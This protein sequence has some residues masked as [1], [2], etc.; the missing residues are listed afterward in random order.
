M[1]L[2][3]NGRPHKINSLIPNLTPP[4]YVNITPKYNMI[5]DHTTY[6]WVAIQ[7]VIRKPITC[8]TS[9]RHP[10]NHFL[11]RMI[12][13][14]KKFGIRKSKIFSAIELGMLTKNPKFL[15]RKKYSVANP[16]IKQF[17]F[18]EWQNGSVNDNHFQTFF[19]HIT[20]QFIF[21]QLEKM[22]ES[23]ILMRRK[24]KMSLRDIIFIQLRVSKI[25]G[26]IKTIKKQQLERDLTYQV[27]HISP[28]DCHLYDHVNRSI[29]KEITEGGE[30]LQQE[31]K[32]FRKITFQ[33][34]EYCN[35]TLTRIRDKALAL[36]W[37]PSPTLNR[38]LRL[39]I[40]VS[41]KSVKFRTKYAG[42]MPFAEMLSRKPLVIPTNKWGGQFLVSP[43]DCATMRLEERALQ[44]YFYFNQN[45]DY[46]KQVQRRC[47]A[48]DINVAGMDCRR[49]CDN[50]KEK[51][52]L[53]FSLV[54]E[55][56]AYIW[57]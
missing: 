54:N 46:C 36:R 2:F 47:P 25:Q 44:N 18:P 41:K 45:W 21:V 52:D 15:R 17:G 56:G 50:S 48:S 30:D 35:L 38:F 27:C 43:L 3:N 8:V 34:Q 14:R 1:A 4:F 5:T 51:D 7:Q 57:S 12:N 10:L 16:M 42:N 29:M 23:V 33:V 9:V 6:D 39:F 19:Q 22:L 11:S 32:T 31:V 37:G 40:N 49:V 20:Q 26:D 24:L 28:L 53:L 13:F 55:P